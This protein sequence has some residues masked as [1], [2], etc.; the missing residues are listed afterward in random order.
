MINKVRVVVRVFTGAGMFG[1]DFGAILVNFF[2][3][4]SDIPAV[5]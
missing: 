3:Y 1:A 4:Y 5:R 2:Y